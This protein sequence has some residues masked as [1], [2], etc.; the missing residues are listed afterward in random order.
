MLDVKIQVRN[1]DL[2]DITRDYIIERLQ[3]FEKLIPDYENLTVT[4]DRLSNSKS[5]NNINEV[6]ITLKMPHAFIKVENKG[7]NIN[8]LFDKLLSPLHKKITR[9][10]SQEERWTKHKEWKS[11]QIEKI[12]QSD[13][14]VAS[15]I[16]STNY[17]PIIRRKFYKDDSPIHPAEAIEKMELLGHEQF[18]FKNIEN[19]KYAII[20]KDKIM[21][22]ELIQ[23]K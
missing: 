10:K 8:T 5:K 2:K 9:Y 23:P 12:S 6:D 7:V 13:E 14:E 4:I 18:L 17:E 19:N 22:Y 1:F 21:G 16:P 3:K 15:D 11:I 20:V